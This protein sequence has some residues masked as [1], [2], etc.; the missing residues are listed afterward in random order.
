L[1]IDGSSAAAPLTNAGRTYWWTAAGCYEA[2]CVVVRNEMVG[3]ELVARDIMR[4]LAP[5]PFAYLREIASGLVGICADNGTWTAWSLAPG[6]KT[7]TGVDPGSVAGAFR[8][9]GGVAFDVQT[10]TWRQSG[11]QFPWSSRAFT[12]DPQAYPLFTSRGE[13]GDAL[14][15][16]VVTALSYDEASATLEIGTDGGL[17]RW[18]VAAPAP[19]YLHPGTNGVQFV[20][21]PGAL[22]NQW[23]TGITRLRRDA[24]GRLWASMPGL[25]QLGRFEPPERWEFQTSA[26]WPTAD[27]AREGWTVTFGGDGLSHGETL[28]TQ[29]SDAFGLGTAPIEGVIDFDYEPGAVWIA[30]AKHGLFK[31]FSSRLLSLPAGAAPR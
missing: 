24:R 3:A 8:L 16:D 9:G 12:V 31:A 25:Q 14:S 7:W 27:F 5:C 21:D 26:N 19:L 18:P 15:F 10:L 17:F 6:Q 13:K 28:W 23:A 20:F 29:S 11:D 4:A 30:T 1:A 2:G 22:G